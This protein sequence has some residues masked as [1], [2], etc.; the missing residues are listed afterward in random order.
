MF[1]RNILQWYKLAGNKTKAAK[2]EKEL[3]EV[4]SKLIF[5][6]FPVTI[7][8]PE[9]VKELTTNPIR[10]SFNKSSRGY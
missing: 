6:S 10:L 3:L 9:Q 7:Y 8:T 5:P 4:K 2:A 1:L